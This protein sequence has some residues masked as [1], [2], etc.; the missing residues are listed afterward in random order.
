MDVY[1]LHQR[2]FPVPVARVGALLD[3]LSGEE[4]RLWP[5]QAW[6]ALR[7]NGPLAVGAAGGHGP[8]RYVIEDYSPRTRVRFRFREPRGFDGFHEFTVHPSESG[9]AVLRHL[10]AMR[11][12]GPARLTWPLIF[13]PLHDALL[14]DALD[15]AEHELIGAV[16]TPARWGLHVR[17]L[18]RALVP[19]RR[20][21]NRTPQGRLTGAGPLSRRRWPRTR[22]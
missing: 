16:R 9:G 3:T 4:D 18:R 15:R 10:L 22:A 11:A 2:E 5:H 12:R 6:P 14:E 21:P 19:C 17:L 1:N 8:V 7:L 20:R 13:R